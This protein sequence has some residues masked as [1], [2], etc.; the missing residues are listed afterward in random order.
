MTE[1]NTDEAILEKIRDFADQAHGDQLRKY[2][3]ER[4]IVHPVRVMQRLKEITSDTTI[5]ASALLHDVLEDT[6][7]TADDIRQFLTPLIGKEPAEKTTRL[8]LELT[9]IYV[10]SVYPRL[11]RRERKQKETQ[12]MA[13]VSA[14]A[15]TVKY[16]DILDN[17]LEIVHQDVDFA[18]VYLKESRQLIQAMTKGN[19][20]LRAAVLESI[21]NGLRI[22]KKSGT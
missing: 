11:N 7:T 18:P 10:K 22:L 20:G 12:R 5:L 9:D 16:A 21:E 2:T 4:Y 14:E 1:Q 8:V 6:P 19:P 13:N 15:Q 3:P 17:S